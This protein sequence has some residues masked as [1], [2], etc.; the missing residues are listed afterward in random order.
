MKR[1][2]NE[3][4]LKH[5]SV[6]GMFGIKEQQFYEINENIDEFINK[7]DVLMKYVAY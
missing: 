7:N 4:I 2:F 3:I 5:I 6:E 1:H